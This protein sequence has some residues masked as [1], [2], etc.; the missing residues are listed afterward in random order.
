[1]SFWSLCQSCMIIIVLKLVLLAG[2][3]LLFKIDESLL[4]MSCH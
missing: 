2:I 4:F 1:M 3:H